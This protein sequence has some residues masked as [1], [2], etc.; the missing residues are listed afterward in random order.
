MH[1]ICTKANDTLSFLWCYLKISAI[2][3]KSDSLQVFWPTDTRVCLYSVESA[4][5]AE[6]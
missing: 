2:F 1:N 4:H 3:V 6:R 5:Q